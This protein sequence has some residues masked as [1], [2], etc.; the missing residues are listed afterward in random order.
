MEA[1]RGATL[2]EAVVASALLGIVVVVA[3]TALDTAGLGARQAVRQAWANCE[4]RIRTEAVLAAPYSAQPYYGAYMAQTTDVPGLQLVH[5]VIY[6]P[7]DNKTV[8]ADAYVY[9]SSALSRTQ[10]SLPL[11]S[12]SEQPPAL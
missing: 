7:R 8:L 3:V 12:C 6:D 10:D 5:I 2:V 4:L 11:P 1:Q 9:K